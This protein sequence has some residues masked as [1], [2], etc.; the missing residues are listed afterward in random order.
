M[1]YSTRLD[2]VKSL[3]QITE[4]MTAEDQDAKTKVFAI[5]A[6]ILI[7]ISHQILVPPEAAVTPP[8]PPSPEPIVHEQI[9]GLQKPTPAEMPKAEMPKAEMP[10]LEEVPEDSSSDDATATTNGTRRDF[11]RFCKSL[12][13]QSGHKFFIMSGANMPSQSFTLG[14]N[15]EGKARLEARFADGT[16]VISSS[17]SGIVRDAVKKLS[18]KNITANGWKR[19]HMKWNN[20]SSYYPIGNSIWLSSQW[21]PK[22]ACFV[23]DIAQV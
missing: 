15:K 17:P 19:L 7:S 20:S 16:L 6:E 22:A 2:T 4:T 8:P 9:Q 23:R 1:S 14:Y 12:N 13:L 3:L 21:N 10:K 5:A 11:T 18:G